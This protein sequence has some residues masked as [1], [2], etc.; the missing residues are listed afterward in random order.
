MMRPDAITW[1][2]LLYLGHMPD[3]WFRSG[4]SSPGDQIIKVV[5]WLETAL[6]V[7]SPVS[8]WNP[9]PEETGFHSL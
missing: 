8:R 9:L 6:S 7:L 4:K 3:H 5:R 2:I 1:Q